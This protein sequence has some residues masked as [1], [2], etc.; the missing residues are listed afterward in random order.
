MIAR[1]RSKQYR[2]KNKDQNAQ[3]P[4]AVARPIKVTGTLFPNRMAKKR[5]IG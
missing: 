4:E 3:V 1:E 5:A 2:Q